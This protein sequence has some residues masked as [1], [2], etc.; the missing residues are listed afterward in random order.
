[1]ILLSYEGFRL[2]S[3]LLVHCLSAPACAAC[4]ADRQ[5]RRQGLRKN[6]GSTKRS[7]GS[8]EFAEDR[9]YTVDIPKIIF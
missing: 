9:R 5:A 2:R 1:M 4:T 3:S 8:T 6:N 7:N